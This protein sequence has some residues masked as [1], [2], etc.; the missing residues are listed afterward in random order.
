VTTGPI[1]SVG[2]TASQSVPVTAGMPITWTAT[3]TG[4][5]APLQYQFW[6]RDA[7]TELWSMVRDYSADRTWTWTPGATDFG[8]VAVQVYIRNTGSGAVY[9]AYYGSGYFAVTP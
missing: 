4:G 1:G 5:T 3:A 2:L 7:Q 9:E 8:R 6:L